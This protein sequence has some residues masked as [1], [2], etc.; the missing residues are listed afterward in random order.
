VFESGAFKI[1]D[2]SIQGKMI[3]DA[4]SVGALSRNVS[5]EITKSDQ[6]QIY[7]PILGGTQ[8]ATSP[9]ELLAAVGVPQRNKSGPSGP[10]GLSSTREHGGKK[11]IAV[12]GDARRGS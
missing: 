8:R 7:E 2:G 1:P 10:K 11:D 9:P 5:R 3:N 4:G 12:V 6:V